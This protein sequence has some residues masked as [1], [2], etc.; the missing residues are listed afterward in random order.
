M[1]LPTGK[2]YGIE[3]W[4]DYNRGIRVGPI[5]VFGFMYEYVITIN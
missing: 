4:L 1:R 5:N 3:Y 2:L